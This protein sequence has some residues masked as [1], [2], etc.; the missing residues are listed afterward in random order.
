MDLIDLWYR[1]IFPKNS[2]HYPSFRFFEK[3]DQFV[4]FHTPL[5]IFATSIEFVASKR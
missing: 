1:Q 5:R 3:V 2:I 4:T